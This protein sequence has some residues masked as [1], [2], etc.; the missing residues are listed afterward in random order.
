MKHVLLSAGLAL[1]ASMAAAQTEIRV[2]YAIPTIWA[3]TQEQ[4]AEAFMA[5]H[6][7]ITIVMDGPAESYAEGVQRLLRENVAGTAPD[8]AYVGLN[9]WRILE[10]RGV[11]YPLDDF[12]PEDTEAAGYTDALL[13]L[14][15]FEGAQHALATSASTMVLYVNPDLVEQAGGSM[16][17]FPTDFDGIIELA[18]EIDALGDNIEGVWIGRHDWR[19]QSLLGSHGGRPLN[20]D[21]TDIT[22]DSEAGLM[23]ASLY[24]RFMTE[25]G[26]PS[27]G[28][29]D[30]R[31]A[32]PAGTL[33]MFFESSS[34]LKRFEEGS[35][36]NFELVVRPT[37]VVAEENVYF[38]TGGSAIVVMTDD[39]ERQAAAWEYLAFVTGPEGQRI[40]VENTGYAPANK[41]VL[42]DAS[43]LGA[44]YE[45][46][47]N[48][49]VGH[50]QV[51][52]HAGPWYAFPGAEGVA[53]TDL[54]GA[55]LVELSEGADVEATVSELANTVRAQL[56]MN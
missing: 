49:L 29:D 50:T 38:P 44:Y 47:P 39:P 27:W 16:E 52:D 23:A 54:I 22:F 7:D 28:Q 46:N 37:P 32:F 30:A 1:T 2:H 43:Y 41:I 42:D 17:D 18:A 53:V 31:Q 4:L 13:S 25:G 36:G 9:R 15:Q 12:L 19:F 11:I 26:M 55:A 51:A 8:V 48:A 20:A 24:N 35:A 40:I 21:E 45:A 14:G 10:D 33:G 34:L 56:G 5:A 6:P 3:D